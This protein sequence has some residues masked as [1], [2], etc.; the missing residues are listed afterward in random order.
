[1]YLL[2][3]PDLNSA[4]DT[5]T[6]LKLGKKKLNEVEMGFE[7]QKA[8]WAQSI[9]IKPTIFFGFNFFIKNQ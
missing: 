4:G 9:Q 3:F 5:V 8:Q 2:C 6:S 1:M 7:I